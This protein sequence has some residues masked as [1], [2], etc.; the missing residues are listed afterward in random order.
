MFFLCLVLGAIV[1]LFVQH[2]LA[3]GI[4]FLSFNLRLSLPI[5][6]VQAFRISTRQVQFGGCLTEKKIA[7]LSLVVE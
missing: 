7:I 2:L 5:W 3:I 4:V 6:H 1:V